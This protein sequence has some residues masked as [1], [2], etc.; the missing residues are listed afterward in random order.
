[1]PKYIH[2][3]EE[4]SIK[5]KN[6]QIFDANM[7]LIGSFNNQYFYKV[8][9]NEELRIMGSLD[10]SSRF[11]SSDPKLMGSIT[12]D[13]IMD[14]SGNTIFKINDGIV[15]DQ[16]GIMLTTIKNP[17]DQFEIMCSIAWAFIN[18]GG[19]PFRREYAH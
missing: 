12:R 16:Y 6:R 17:D 10:E 19:K 13:R 7:N 3:T 15:Y 8:D 14:A 1:M 9:E 11:Y 5:Y 18:N 2:L 4:L